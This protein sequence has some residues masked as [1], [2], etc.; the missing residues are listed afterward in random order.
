MKALLLTFLLSQGADLTTTVVGMN[1]GCVEA[2]PLYGRTASVQQVVMTKSAG[3]F[4]VAT[5]AWGAH[6]EGYTKQAKGILLV[7]IAASAI[8]AVINVRRIPRCSQH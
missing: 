3:T 2:N 6:K 1:R 5:I 7:G 8:P 4:V